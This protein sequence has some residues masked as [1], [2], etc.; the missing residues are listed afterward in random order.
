MA[1]Y[2]EA[3]KLNPNLGRA[4]LLRGLVRLKRGEAELADKDFDRGFKLDPDLHREFD[5]M[6]EQLRPAKKT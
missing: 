5:P 3:I 1:D 6:I 2:E 4:Y